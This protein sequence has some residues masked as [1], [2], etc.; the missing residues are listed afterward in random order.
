MKMKIDL[1]HGGVIRATAMLSGFLS[2]LLK[3]HF[4]P[5]DP[6][7]GTWTVKVEESGNRKKLSNIFAPNLLGTV[8]QILSS[9]K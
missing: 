8:I 7:R 9:R 5:Y 1:T 2:M 6:T 4:L 3:N